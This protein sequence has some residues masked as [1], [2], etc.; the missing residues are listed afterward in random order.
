MRQTIFGTD[1]ASCNKKLRAN[2]FLCIAMFLGIAGI[3]VVCTLGR[4]EQ[5]HTVMLICNI[6]ADVLGGSLLI[7]RL[8][9]CVFPLKR[10]LRLYGQAN[11]EA[12]GE[13]L[14]LTDTPI[15]YAGMDCHE[16]TLSDR[17][18]FLPADTMELTAGI[19]YR[20]RLKGNLIVE[21]CD[22]EEY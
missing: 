20:F 18:L 13:V 2:I 10:M 19:Y 4:T 9:L 6:A 11:Q 3:H 16:V 17:R 1:W 21:V 7:A 12:F 15:H 22:D 14:A 5:N 8:S